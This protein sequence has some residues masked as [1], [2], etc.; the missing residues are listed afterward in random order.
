MCSET[1][2][3]VKS[4]T[5]L[6]TLSTLIQGKINMK[7][8]GGGEGEVVC[9]RYEPASKKANTHRKNVICK[10]LRKKIRDDCEIILSWIAEGT[11]RCFH[12]A[13]RY[14]K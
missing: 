11:R 1:G 3:H 14:L 5:H 4:V 13:E 7:R 8:G 12:S 2:M 9:P 10:K 6:Y